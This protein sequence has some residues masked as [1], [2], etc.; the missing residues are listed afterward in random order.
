MIGIKEENLLKEIALKNRTLEELS[1]NLNLSERSVRY[2][3]KNLNEYFKQEKIAIEIILKKNFVEFIGDLK[4]LE[5]RSIFPKFNPYIYTQEERLEIL[6]NFLLFTEE[7]FYWE[8][9]QNLVDISE[10]TFK[11]DWKLLREEF[12]KLDINIINRKYFTVLEATED[13]IRNYMLKNI[14]KYKINSNNLNLTDK[15]INKIIDS[16]FSTV[17]FKGLKNLLKQIS[18]KL[19]IIVSDDAFNIMKYTLALTLKRMDKTPFKKENIKNVEFLRNTEEYKIIK[20]VME[21]YKEE[22]KNYIYDFEILNLTEYFLG[23][24]SYNFKY[25]FYENWIHIETI[26]DKIIEGVEKELNVDFE[27]DAELFEGILNHLKPMVYRIRKGIKLENSITREIIEESPEIFTALKNNINILEKFIKCKVDDDELS[28][29]TVFFKLAIK[30]YRI[31]KI[32]RIII[33]CSFGYG[34]SKVLEARL[35]EKFNV[36]IV[37]TLP[38]HE[39]NQKILLEEEIDLIVTT[40]K[41]EEIDTDIPIITV[42]PL[43]GIEDINKLRESGLK[44]LTVSDYYDMFIDI[45]KKNCKIENEERLKK[46]LADLFNINF[47]DMFEQKTEK[48]EFK[49]FINSKKIKIIQKINSFEEG[50][51]IAGELLIENK[52]INREY[53]DSCV[54]VFKKQGPYMLI[55]PNTILPHSDNFKNVIKTD[56]SFIKLKTPLNLEYDENIVKVENIIFLASSDGKEHRDSLL[57]LK[58]LIDKCKIESIFRECKTEKEILGILNRINGRK[59]GGEL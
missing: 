20:K 55:G 12:Y 19:N 45:I 40:I 17:D 36:I 58:Y 26:V 43:L 39:L 27:K 9:Y 18:K 25:S 7:K 8:N 54:K 46:D 10:S 29:L 13:K 42:S 47:Q 23:S 59:N 11:K 51:K 48:K 57:N 28:Y 16:Y 31:N 41:L 3:I 30:K 6:I 5:E 14:V 24:H 38:A 4:L 37:K 34:V 15:A 32:P 1:K 35:K 56:Y 44:E 49:E 22:F 33:L 2:K 53:I 50:I 52:S 21:K